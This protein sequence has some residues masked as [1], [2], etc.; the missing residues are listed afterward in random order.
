[1]RSVKQMTVAIAAATLL[2]SQVPAA[3]AAPKSPGSAQ[4]ASPAPGKSGEHN[5]NLNGGQASPATPGSQKSDGT[6]LPG[7]EQQPVDKGA[8]SGKGQQ[9][10]AATATDSTT[11]TTTTTETKA[12]AA[13]AHV[14]QVKTASREAAKAERQNGTTGAYLVYVNGERL[15][16]TPLA[17]NGRT[18]V[19]FRALAEDLG[20]T[21]S[22]DPS[23][24]TVTMV[25]G[26]TT[27]VITI[28]ASTATV[29][30]QT[31]DLA[32]PAEINNGSTFVPLRFIAE[33]L[34]ADVDYDTTT[35]AI[36]VITSPDAGT[37]PT[38]GTTPTTG[39][40]TGSTTTT[41]TTGTDTGSTTTTPTTGT[42]TGST[43]TTPTTGT[44][45]GSTTTT[46][47]TGTDTG[48]TTTTPTT[49]T[50]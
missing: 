45:T 25:K 11:T 9:A 27:V 37:T 22:W 46:P 34:G 43:T 24:R 50:P 48:S 13:K 15:N 26:E 47:S 4:S 8:N 18:L 19:P 39:T 10:D 35:G 6:V 21:V 31:V 2:L 28:G 41:P 33:A 5:P 20:A 49:T 44:D 29:N 23:T 38:D 42:D 30:G 7:S 14:D 17:H 3:F 32:V 36:T 16:L 40:D 1:M 12:A